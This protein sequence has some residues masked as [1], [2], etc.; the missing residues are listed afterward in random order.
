MFPDLSEF[1]GGHG[2]CLTISSFRLRLQV[3]KSSLLDPDT[4]KAVFQRPQSIE[5]EKIDQAFLIE[6]CC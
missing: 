3:W 6:W 5:E 1:Q 4:M 2:H